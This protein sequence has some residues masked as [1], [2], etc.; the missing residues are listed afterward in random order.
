MYLVIL[1]LKI[2]LELRKWKNLFGDFYVFCKF[3]NKKFAYIFCFLDTKWVLMSSWFIF[4]KILSLLLSW[5][6]NEDKKYHVIE[7]NWLVCYIKK[8]L[9]TVLNKAV[10]KNVFCNFVFEN[11]FRFEKM[12]KLVWWFL[13]PL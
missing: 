3:K 11:C 10:M 6:L 7:F 2:V 13:C 9:K 12:E 4:K 1:F 8:N 5:N